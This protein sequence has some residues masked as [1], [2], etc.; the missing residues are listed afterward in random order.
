MADGRESGLG[1]VWPA[2]RESLLTLTFG[3][4]KTAAGSARLATENLSHLRQTS[5]ASARS[6]SKA[7]L[8]DAIDGLFNDLDRA[9]QDR[10]TAHMITE[11][12]KRRPQLAERLEELLERRGWTLFEHEAVPLQ[13]RLDAVPDTLAEPVQAGLTKALRRYRD[14]DLDGAITAIAG[15]IDTLTEEIYE[16]EGLDNHKRTSFQERT[17]LA[18]RTR[19]AA[20]EAALIAMDADERRR[21]WQAQD[22][23]VN[24]AADVLGAYR[25]NYADAHGA[26]PADDRIVQ[27]ALHAAVFLIRV[28]PTRAARRLTSPRP[29]AQR[30]PV[31]VRCR[32]TSAAPRSW[33]ATRT[34]NQ[35]FGRGRLLW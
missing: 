8:A 2:L 5:A 25:R 22:R 23:A 10:V 13:L 29:T 33:S 34:C 1:G 27:A 20:F 19:Q 32:T 9:A 12:L 7:E 14:G 6:A 3:D 28:S 31:E 18:H 17:I 30:P 4:M 26:K 21:T 24:G 11:L 15:L 35:L 16:A